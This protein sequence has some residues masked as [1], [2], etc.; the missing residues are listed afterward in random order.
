[1]KTKGLRQLAALQLGAPHGAAIAVLDVGREGLVAVTGEQAAN[2]SLALPR[3]L[4][5]QVGF[6][7][8]V[9]SALRH[10]CD[11]CRREIREVAAGQLELWDDQGGAAF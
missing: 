2:D 3:W 10:A 6:V 11:E 7:E 4:V 9:S 1:M 5:R 8:G